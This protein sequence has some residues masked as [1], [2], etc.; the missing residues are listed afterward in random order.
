MATADFKQ[1]L[2]S[3]EEIEI[4]VTGRKS[5]RKISFP[6]WF[7]LEGDTL[8]L[9]PVTGSESDWY[10]NILQNPTM[11]VAA[12]GMEVTVNVEPITA[13]DK[14]QEIVEKFRAK[15][16]AANIQRYYS[17]LDVAVEARLH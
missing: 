12:R 16:G 10:K 13:P 2:S 3:T 8:Y 17:K 11:T 5:G 7:V 9:L 14:V 15:Y 6:I 1:A 4:T